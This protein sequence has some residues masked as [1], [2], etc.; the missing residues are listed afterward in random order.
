MARTKQSDRRERRKHWRSGRQSS[1]RRSSSTAWMRRNCSWRLGQFDWAVRE[2]RSG[3]DD[4]PIESRRGDRV[5]GAACR[6][7]CRI[8]SSTKQAA[9]ALEPL[10]DAM[11]KNPDVKRTYDECAWRSSREQSHFVPEANSLAA[12]LHY[13]RACHFEQEHDFTRE[14]EELL[15]AIKHDETDADVLIAMYRV[16]DAD[17]AWMADTREA[18]PEA[19]QARS[20]NRSTTIRT[21]RFLTTNGPG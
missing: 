7:C 19:G 12:R 13:L 9:D 10:A 2:Y 15:K 11:E 1:S 5:A 20:K 8:T 14:R 17:D 18:D 21:T 4:Q 3:F 6:I 16:G